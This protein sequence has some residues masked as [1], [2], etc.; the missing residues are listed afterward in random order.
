MDEIIP[1]LHRLWGPD[2]AAHGQ[3]W[4]GSGR[5]P[6]PPV[7]CGRL[8][9]QHIGPGIYF[10]MACDLPSL[11]ASCLGLF[12]GSGLNYEAE[13][14]FSLT[15]RPQSRSEE[16]HSNRITCHSGAPLGGAPSGALVV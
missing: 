15:P 9:W 6:R 11:A 8:S 14:P 13:A 5:C 2:S 12:A 7:H 3:T 1:K 16:F 4:A 10:L